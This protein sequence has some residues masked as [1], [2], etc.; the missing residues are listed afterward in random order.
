MER[1]DAYP[2]IDITCS[3]LT[4]K[5]YGVSEE[6]NSHLLKDKTFS[7]RNFGVVNVTGAR[8]DRTLVLTIYDQKG[9]KVWDYSIKSSDL[10]Y[11]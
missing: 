7:Q 6:G 11:K 1:P 2:L 4:S 3:P 10:T 9:E 5:T 8:L